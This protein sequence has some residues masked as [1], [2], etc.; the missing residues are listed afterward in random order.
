MRKLLLAVVM[1]GALAI[2]MGAE[3]TQRPNILF[4]LTDDQGYGDIS[5][6]GNPILK[7]PQMDRLHDEAADHGEQHAG[8][9]SQQGVVIATRK[10]GA[11]DRSREQRIAHKTHRRL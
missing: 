4:I 5:C 2:V 10:I 6:H 1:F 11:A 7:T 8:D 9:R 3:P